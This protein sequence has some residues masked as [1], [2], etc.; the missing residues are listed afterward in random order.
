IDSTASGGAGGLGREFLQLSRPAMA[1]LAK[2]GRFGVFLGRGFYGLLLAAEPG[3]RAWADRTCA[4]R[5]PRR[6]RSH[7]SRTLAAHEVLARDFSRLALAVRT[8]PD[9]WLDRRLLHRQ[10]GSAQPAS[11]RLQ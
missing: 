4:G 8:H 11:L 1:T 2:Q 7:T 5:N 6:P 3:S 10:L 9:Q